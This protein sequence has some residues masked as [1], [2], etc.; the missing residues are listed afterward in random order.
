MQCELDHVRKSA[1]HLAQDGN[2]VER[3][4][5]EPFG[6]TY[7]E[8]GFHSV[9]GMQDGCI[10]EAEIPSRDIKRAHRKTDHRGHVPIPP[11]HT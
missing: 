8:E 7:H 5:F 6:M 10:V 2:F 1:K 9:Y 4:G 11:A 3:F